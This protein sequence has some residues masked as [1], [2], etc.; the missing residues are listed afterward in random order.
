MNIRQADLDAL[1][2]AFFTVN[3][4]CLE[5]AAKVRHG[6]PVEAQETI[7]EARRVAWSGYQGAKRAGAASPEAMPEPSGGPVPLYLLDTPKNR[8]LLSALL[9]AYN[10]AAD[11][12]TERGHDPGDGFAAIIGSY[13]VDKR[14]E[15]NGPVGAARE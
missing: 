2:R 15:I 14:D 6:N 4:H 13:L 8:R 9:E 10:A 11:V 5:A 7:A 3:S 12:D 1:A